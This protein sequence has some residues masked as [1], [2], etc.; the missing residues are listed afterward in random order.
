M[1]HSLEISL[2]LPRSLP[3]FDQAPEWVGDYVNIPFAD[4]GRDIGGCD[5]YG[6][7]RIVYRDVL[8]IRLPEYKEVYSN[9]KDNKGMSALFMNE[10]AKW[11]K[12]ISP[13]LFLDVVVLRVDGLPIHCGL[14]VAKGKML[15]SLRACNSAIESYNELLWKNRIVGF[16]RHAEL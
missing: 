16:Y 3:S 9:T 2:S 7:I 12:V 6:L 5:C 15:H 1:N 13:I 11:K 10:S 4:K 14:V 8:G